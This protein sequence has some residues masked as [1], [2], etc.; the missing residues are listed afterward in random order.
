MWDDVGC[1]RYPSLYCDFF[2]SPSPTRTVPCC[3]FVGIF[4]CSQVSRFPRTGDGSVLS[5]QH[6]IEFACI[7]CRHHFHI[8]MVPYPEYDQV[9]LFVVDASRSSTCGTI[10]PHFQPR[11]FRGPSPWSE[12]STQFPRYTPDI[13]VSARVRMY[14]FHN[15][16]ISDAVRGR[17]HSTKD[18]YLQLWNR[19]EHLIRC[20]LLIRMC[21]REYPSYCSEYS[22]FHQSLTIFFRRT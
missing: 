14:I 22:I 17:E 13:P 12:R 1:T 4:R 6:V 20:R 18:L 15:C 21:R 9:Q 11:F 8:S 10:W 5:A 19:H 16:Q 7:C 3:V 2:K